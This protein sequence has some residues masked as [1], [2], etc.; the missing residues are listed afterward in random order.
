[1]LPFMHLTVF[2]AIMRTKSVSL[3]AETL[4]VPQPTLSRYLKQLRDHFGNQLFVRTRTGLE[5][6][7]IAISSAPAVSQALALYR[8]RLSGEP[9][10]DP[11]TSARDFHIA[12]SDVG[13]LLVLPRMLPIRERACGRDRAGRSEEHTSEI[14]S[15]MH[16][17][18]SVLCLKKNITQYR[19][20]S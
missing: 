11:L 10:F 18:S 4:D 15:I 6:T 16:I 13:P 19:Q 17:S 1:M 3:A 12:A 2:E 20:L 14:P 5:P 8:T 7:S 9:S